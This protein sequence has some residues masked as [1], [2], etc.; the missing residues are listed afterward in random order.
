MISL[1]PPSASLLARLEQAP[2]TYGEVGATQA[3]L[4][5]GY[6]HLRHRVRVGHGTDAFQQ[7][8]TAI[9]RCIDGRA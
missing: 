6:E 2:L 4:P 8:A 5:D 1:H 9:G 3:E 7:A